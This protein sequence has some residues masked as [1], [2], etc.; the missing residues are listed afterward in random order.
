MDIR[1]NHKELEN[2]GRKKEITS[3]GL[4]KGRAAS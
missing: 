3:V 4:E 1:E 2:L